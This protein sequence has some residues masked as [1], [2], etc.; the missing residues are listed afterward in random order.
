MTIAPAPKVWFPLDLDAVARVWQADKAGTMRRCV[1]RA[2]AVQ[3]LAS[4]CNHLLGRATRRLFAMG[5]PSTWAPADEDPLIACDYRDGFSNAR[6]TRVRILTMPRSA[7]VGDCYASSDSGAS[8]TPLLNMTAG[9]YTFPEDELYAEYVVHRGAAAGTDAEFGI[10]IVN[11][12]RILDAYVFE[13]ET[14]LLDDTENEA[15]T[16]KLVAVGNDILAD[17]AEDIRSGM[18]HLRAE[19]LPVICTWSAPGTADATKAPAITSSTYVNVLDQTVTT[20]TA[21]SP[22]VNVAAE[23]CGRGISGVTHARGLFYVTVNQTPPAGGSAEIKL[24]G[25]TDNVELSIAAGSTSWQSVDHVSLDT[26]KAW[27]DVTA[28]GNKIDIH[29]KVSGLNTE[30]TIWRFTILM[31]D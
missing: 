23:Y 19:N 30:L 1:N 7:G 3:A 28:N 4:G 14:P 10:T 17:M 20:R 18:A 27:D 25:P 15:V 22:G 31:E 24:I 29:A 21:T 8:V 6:R 5:M 16:T 26:A 2:S 12:Y 9:S 11:G 13:D